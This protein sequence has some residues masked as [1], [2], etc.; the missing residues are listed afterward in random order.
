MNLQV[1]WNRV[2]AIGGVVAVLIVVSGVNYV[3]THSGHPAMAEYWALLNAAAKYSQQL[4]TEGA[5]VPESISLEELSR[6]GLV[7]QGV[8]KA[9]EGLR[10]TIS[11]K[12]DAVRPQ[13]SLMTVTFPDGLQ[14]VAMGDGSIHERVRP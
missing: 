5:V 9:F 8:A 3:R 1:K 13:D 6:R 7:Q 14:V 2:W 11:L 4:K 10:V 12:P